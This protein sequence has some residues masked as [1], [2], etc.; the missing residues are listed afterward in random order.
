MEKTKDIKDFYRS[1]SADLMNQIEDEKILKWIYEIVKA[2]WK[3]DTA[4]KTTR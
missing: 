2:G 4:G 1:G 3:E